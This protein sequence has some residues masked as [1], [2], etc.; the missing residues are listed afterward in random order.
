MMRYDDICITCC[1]EV[2]IRCTCSYNRGDG[3]EQEDYDTL[4]HLEILLRDELLLDLDLIAVCFMTLLRQGS[5]M[6][7]DPLLPLFRPSE[8]RRNQI[9]L[10]TIPT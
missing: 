4:I 6:G 2:G 10:C 9:I 3:H 1:S 8:V 7:V 5:K